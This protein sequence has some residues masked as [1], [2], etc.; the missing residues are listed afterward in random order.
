MSTNPA[1]PRIKRRVLL[2]SGAGAAA[3]ASGLGVWASQHA[4]AENAADAGQAASDVGAAQSVIGWASLNGGVSGGSEQVDV[5]S[6]SEF[7]AAIGEGGLVVRLTGSI[8]ISGMNNVAANTTVTGAS[9]A[10]ITGGGLNISGDSNII[11]TNLT[12]DDWDDDAINVQ[13][14]ATNIWI[15]HNT[16][17]V[18]YDGCVDVKRGSDYVTIDWNR[19]DGHDKNMLLGH[20]DDNAGQDVGHLRVTYHHNYFN[21]TN[22]RNPRVRFGEQVHVL[23]NYYR[24]VGSYGV[25]TTM[26]AGVIV[27]ANYFENT[28]DP[29]HIGEGSSD[30]G[31][32]VEFDNVL[33][34]SG[35]ILTNGSV[36]TDL[37]YSYSADPADQIP[38]I[39]SDGA[40]AS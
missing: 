20:S 2:A 32:L 19:F 3:A 17:G 36:N 25:A 9:G 12:F 33:D 35:P 14:S 40:G 8:S 31:R 26:D 7:L 18:G 34:G 38:G 23:N 27:E 30:P 10:R 39:V 16:F 5:S 22:Q 1:V 29:T 37:P 15:H 4:S 28:E 11:I 6:A 21:G 24:N 13:E